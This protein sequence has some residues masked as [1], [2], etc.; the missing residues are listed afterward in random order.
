MNALAHSYFFWISDLRPARP[1]H[2]AHHHR[3]HPRRR[4][5]RLD[6]HDQP[7]PTGI[8]WPAA[9]IAALMLPAERHLTFP[10]PL[11]LSTIQKAHPLP[12][13]LQQIP[14]TRA[15]DMHRDLS[16]SHAGTHIREARISTIE[17]QRTPCGRQLGSGPDSF[18]RSINMSNASRHQLTV[19]HMGIPSAGKRQEQHRPILRSNF[20]R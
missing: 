15:N 10:T 5:P 8:G 12:L 3:R 20:V 11:P 13:V 7:T 19:N 14:V 9:L 1:L 6:H 2:P 17:C 4:R 16:N 18:S